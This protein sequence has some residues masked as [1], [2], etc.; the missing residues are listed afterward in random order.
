MLRWVFSVPATKKACEM[1]MN[2]GKPH[3]VD[4]LKA[5]L[6]E[7]SDYHSKLTKEAAMGKYTLQCFLLKYQPFFLKKK[8]NINLIVP[9]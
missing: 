7:C 9:I 2:S 1:I 5:A 8:V 3:S 4:E 6:K